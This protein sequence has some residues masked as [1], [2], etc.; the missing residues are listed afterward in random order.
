[1]TKVRVLFFFLSLFI[2]TILG[3]IAILYAT[4]FRFNRET[5]QVSAHGLLNVTSDPNGAQIIVNGELKSA[6]NSTV[7]LTPNEYQLVIKKD[8][9]LTWKKTIK[10]EKEIVTAVDAS[11]FQSA[12][13][14]SAIT[15]TGIVNPQLSPDLGKIVYAVESDDPLTQGLWVMETSNLPI[16]FNRQPHRITDGSMKDFEWYW[17]PDSRQILMTNKPLEK[18]ATTK[19][20]QAYKELSTILQVSEYI[21]STDRIVSLSSRET[22]L[23]QWNDIKNQQI[24]AQLSR[25]PKELAQIFQEKTQIIAF[26]PD[27]TKIL[28]SATASATIT[29][30][31]IKPL[32]G[33]STQ[34]Q[35]RSTEKGKV[36]VFD[37][38]E[39][40][41]FEITTDDSVVYWLPN[42]TNLMIPQKDKISIVDY[43]G[44]NLQSVYSGSYVYPTAYPSPSTGRLFVLTN[45]GATGAPVNLYSLNLK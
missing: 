36:Y 45:L 7:T 27:E 24:E 35:K 34:Q 40:R 37:I 43:D 11:L 21:K 12:P 31:I 25:L 14:L 10:I 33:S 9:Y 4:G 39:D 32:P 28:Y 38:K 19:Q 16:L 8:G 18:N 1:M 23:S 6:T 42:S 13:S 22:I 29:E 17:S 26:S 20:K 2:I 41:N 5:G 3:T 44:T 15:F 30:G